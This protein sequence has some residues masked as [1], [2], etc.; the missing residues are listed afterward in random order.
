LCPG[1]IV[2]VILVGVCVCVFAEP[3]NEARLCVVRSCSLSML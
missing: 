1:N 3:T 2:C